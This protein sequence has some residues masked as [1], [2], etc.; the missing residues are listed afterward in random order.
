MRIVHLLM[1]ATIV[2]LAVSSLVDLAYAQ[3]ARI[4]AP[5][6]YELVWHDE[7]EHPQI[8]LSKWSFEVNAWGGG[9]HE[10]QYYTDRPENVFIRDGK[11]I[12]RAEREHFTGPEGT[13]EYTSARMRTKYRGDWK[14]GW[15]EIKAK[16]PCG[17]G[18]WP[19]IW[20]LPTD[21]VYGPWTA[22][23]EIDIM[24]LIGHEPNRVHGTLHY[25]GVPPNNLHSG[26]FFKLPAGSDFC[27][28]FHVFA[29]EWSPYSAKVIINGK[30]QTRQLVEIRWYVDGKNYERQNEWFSSAA[31]YPA[32]FDQRFHLILNVAVGGDWP[33]RPDASTKFPQEMQVEYVRVFQRQSSSAQ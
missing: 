12:I 11:L 30:P 9:N 2:L 3:H 28:D 31:P 10:L 7:F 23:G 22:S 21:W 18:L 16:L 6:G 26:A 19:A 20:L 13:R 15:F 32:P 25:G 14:Y 27:E 8:D 33:G 29:L 4:K 5:K 17:R 1:K 24:E